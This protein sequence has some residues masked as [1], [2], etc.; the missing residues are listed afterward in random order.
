M[1]LNSVETGAG[2]R[3]A[4]LLHGLMG[5]A[6][7]WSPVAAALAA[8]GYRVLAL[9]LPGHGDSPRDPHSTV[10]SAADAVVETVRRRPGRRRLIAIGHSYGGTVLAA[11]ADRLPVDLAVYVDTTCAFTGGAD[12]DALAAAYA[13]DRALRRDPE[14]LRASRAYYSDE[15][16]RFEARAADRF[17]P[18]TA[19]AISSGGDVSHPPAPGSIVVR[20]EPSRFVG[21]EDAAA[22]SAR[23][24]E[25][26][27]IQGAAHTVWYSHFDEFVG[28]LPEVFG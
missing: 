21:D 13:R 9:D 6:E 25:V 15:A 27:S 12:R 10:E 28:S 1:L 23:G 14:T 16:V 7:S 18:E 8:R 4:L 24:V 26:R 2:R 19:A 20:A 11:A 22:F 17:D 5:S 3:T